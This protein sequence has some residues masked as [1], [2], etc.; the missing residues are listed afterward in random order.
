[1]G[2]KDL[3]TVA[4]K[5]LGGEYFQR[6]L[7][8][9]AERLARAANRPLYKPHI[10]WWHDRAWLAPLAPYLDDAKNLDRRFTLVQWARS[11]QRLCGSTAECGVY[12]GVGSALICK[13][14]EGTY[15]GGELH[16]GFDSFQGLSAPVARDMCSATRTNG[17]AARLVM[18]RPW[19]SGDLACQL[20]SAQK[21]VAEF[22]YCRFI[23]GWIPECFSASGERTYRFLHVDVDLFRPT[24]DSLVYFYPRMAADGVI[25]LDDYGLLTCQGAR[26]AVDEFFAGKPESIVELP[27]GQAVVIKQS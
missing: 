9:A 22:P 1:M 23:Q 6:G 11:V 10:A 20:T 8:S 12:T 17:Y 24:L 26:G 19:R 21:R 27:T 3:A 4:K 16:L 14:L 25:L 13:A 2:L 15:G 18:S 7:D 5:Y